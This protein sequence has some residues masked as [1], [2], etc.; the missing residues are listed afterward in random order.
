LQQLIVERIATLEGLG[1]QLPL[2]R[3]LWLEPFL[4]LLGFEVEEVPP[5]QLPVAPPK[6]LVLLLHVLRREGDRI[7]RRPRFALL[8]TAVGASLD[9]TELR[10]SADRVCEQFEL[11]EAILTDGLNWTR[12]RPWTPWH[13]SSRHVRSLLGPASGK[14]LVEFCFEF[15]A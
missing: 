7:R 2:V 15:G 12:H 6:A 13:P 4:R 14:A 5:A 3:S 8:L 10:G 11:F 1:E 9:D